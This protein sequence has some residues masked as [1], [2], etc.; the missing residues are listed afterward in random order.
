MSISQYIGIAAAVSIPF[1]AV[2]IVVCAAYVDLF[3]EGR[4]P[5]PDD[6]SVQSQGPSA[7]SDKRSI[8]CNPAGK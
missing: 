5:Y 2:L 4:R 6:D 8:S 3:I 7:R 1:L